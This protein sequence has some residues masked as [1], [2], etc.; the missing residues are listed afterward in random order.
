MTH[1]QVEKT[2]VGVEKRLDIREALSAKATLH[3]QPSDQRDKGMTV[4]VTDFSL[5][6]VGVSGSQPVPIGAT[7][8]IVLESKVLCVNSMIRIK[9]CEFSYGQYWIGAEFID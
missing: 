4:N 7:Y 9:R 1:E 6:G 5:T 3:P 2:A 8:R